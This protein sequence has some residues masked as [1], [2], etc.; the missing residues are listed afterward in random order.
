MS[1]KY[2]VRLTTRMDLLPK[3]EVQIQRDV[4]GALYK[5]ALSHNQQPCAAFILGSNEDYTKPRFDFALLAVA[6]ESWNLLDAEDLVVGLEKGLDP[7]RRVAKDFQ[8]ELIGVGVAWETLL[9]INKHSRFGSLVDFARQHS[10]PYILE[11][12]VTFGESIWASSVYFS[13]RFPHDSLQHKIVSQRPKAAVDNPRRIKSVW[14]QA[15]CQ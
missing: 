7:I 6:S 8:R 11:V 3:I 4:C 2:K 1:S 10:I 15:L 5:S 9:M 12:P 14:K 13:N